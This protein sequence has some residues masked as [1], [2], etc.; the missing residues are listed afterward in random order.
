MPVSAAAKLER[1][2]FFGSFFFA[3]EKETNPA[4]RAIPKLGGH[5]AGVTGSFSSSFSPLFSPPK[6]TKKSREDIVLP[7]F[8]FITE[9]YA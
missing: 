4:G 6:K 9:A 2:L 7:A 8:Q 5:A 3:L 1:A